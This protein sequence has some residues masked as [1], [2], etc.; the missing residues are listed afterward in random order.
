[1]KKIKTILGYDVFADENK[2][3]FQRWT[4]KIPIEYKGKIYSFRVNKLNK[5]MQE[6]A[7]RKFRKANN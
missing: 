7:L 4:F 2:I 5:K 3:I 6:Y 1:M